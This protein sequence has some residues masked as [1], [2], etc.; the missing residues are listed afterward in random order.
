MSDYE[1]DILEVRYDEID[2]DEI[3]DAIEMQFIAASAT[4]P[5]CQIQHCV[6]IHQ[7]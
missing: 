2:D 1:E 5:G 3:D 7:G 6:Y 4:G